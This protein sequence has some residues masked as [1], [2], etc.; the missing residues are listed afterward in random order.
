MKNIKLHYN[1]SL[2]VKENAEIC[3]VTQ[4]AIR[5]YIQRNNI[6]RKFDNSYIKLNKIKE[7][8]FHLSQNNE[9]VTNQKIKEITA[10]SLNTISKYRNY[11]SSEKE[12]KS[13]TNN[14][15]SF[16]LNNSSRIIKSVSYNQHDILRNILTLHIP[17]KI[18]DCDLCFSKGNF[19][20]NKI[21]APIHKYDKYPLNEDVKPL[22]EIESL[23]NNIFNSIVVD[24]PFIIS[25]KDN[26]IDNGKTNM[27]HKRFNS[28]TN[29]AELYQANN[30]VIEHSARLLQKYGVLVMKTMDTVSSGKQIFTSQY[31]INKCTEC[32]LELL[33]TF[34]LIAKTKLLSPKI[35]TQH[36]ARK[37]HSYFFVFKKK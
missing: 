27:I 33:D 24:L 25:G 34:I 32:G 2:S 4:S 22:F 3:N 15:S 21:P 13:N 17:S 30:Y 23:P 11:I 37:Y 6:D 29:A 8:I 35:T 31:V 1:P 5:Q 20:K 18:F 16:A 12:L 19:Y 7:A 10:Y 26:F 9:K 28:F 36:Y 14:V